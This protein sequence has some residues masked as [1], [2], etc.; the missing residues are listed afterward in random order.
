MKV[1]RVQMFLN[2]KQTHV[3]KSF[4]DI[5]S[6]SDVFYVFSDVILST[7]EIAS[8]NEKSSDVNV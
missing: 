2:N 3:F 6:F 4:S 1:L 8:A 7:S 5:F